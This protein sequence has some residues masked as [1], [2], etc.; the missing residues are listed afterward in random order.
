M[1]RER[2]VI[3]FLSSFFWID[4]SILMLSFVTL[5]ESETNFS[6]ACCGQLPRLLP[7]KNTKCKLKNNADVP[8]VALKQEIMLVV[9]VQAVMGALTDD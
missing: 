1:E 7:Q 9:G 6:P 8:Q 3:H 2:P 4:F 5:H